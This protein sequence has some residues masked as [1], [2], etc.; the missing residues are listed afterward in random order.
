[1]LR[2]MRSGILVRIYRPHSYLAKS[3][4]KI[5]GVGHLIAARRVEPDVRWW[6]RSPGSIGLD[7]RAFSV[8]DQQPMRRK[9]AV[10]WIRMHRI[11]TPNAQS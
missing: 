8:I 6:V 9:N 7:F 1:M 10:Y 3:K 11:D 4:E 5:G 2:Q